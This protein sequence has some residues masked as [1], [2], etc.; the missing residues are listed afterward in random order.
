MYKRTFCFCLSQPT[1]N[2][3]LLYSIIS[4]KMLMESSEQFCRSC[5]ELEAIRLMVIPKIIHL[6]VKWSTYK[7]Q[8]LCKVLA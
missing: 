5:T 6:N 8:L 4:F 1:S 2:H 7:V 3:C